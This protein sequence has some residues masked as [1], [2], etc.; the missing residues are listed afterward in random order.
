MDYV[1]NS[2]RMCI[3]HFD[4]EFIKFNGKRSRLYWDLNPVHND[5]SFYKKITYKSTIIYNLFKLLIYNLCQTAIG[6]PL[7]GRARGEPD[8]LERFK[9]LDSI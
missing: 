5:L 7:S 3:L 9:E 6:K 1:V 2:S 4:K 8:E